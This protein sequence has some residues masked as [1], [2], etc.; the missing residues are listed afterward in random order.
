MILKNKNFLLLFLS[1]FSSVFGDA[2]LFILLL[3]MLDN[4]NTSSVGLSLFYIY[5]TIPAL[6]FSVPAGAII[7]KNYLQKVMSI[8][9]INRIIL[10][11][12][13]ILLQFISSPSQ[14]SIY[15]LVFMVMANHVFYIPANS[16]LLTKIVKKEDVVNANSHIQITMMVAR[17]G[18]YACSAWLIKIGIS[19][20]NILFIIA[21]IYALSLA[22]IIS[23]KPYYKSHKNNSNTSYFQDI[24][25]GMNYIKS[26]RIFSR[27]F[28]IFG[29]SWI[30][31]SSIDIFLISY[32]T[33]I[34]NRGPEDL[35]LITT[36]SLIG[37]TIG[38]LLAPYLYRKIDAKIGILLSSLFFSIVIIL[39]SLKLPIWILLISL[40]I[41]GITQGLF[42]IFINTYLQTHVQENLL[43][44][45]YSFYNLL[46]TGATLPG[47]LLFGY[48]I[49]YMGVINT[50][51]IISIYLFFAS[52]MTMAILPKMNSN[53]KLTETK[54]LNY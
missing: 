12:S 26:N 6:L 3:T 5:S 38:S 32:L 36:F 18:S 1:R 33:N 44:R 41:G 20:N 25:E 13:L 7:E 39:F 11:L 17:L 50:G 37:I 8:T 52:L 30:V 46:Y 23:I 9:N 22:F 40:F 54:E 16:S 48:L 49:K 43:A 45:V 14:T 42:L 35:Y 15:L 4:L 27:L 53:S 19:F 21:L 24:S 34:L 47:Y 2:M 51:F 31:G 28:L 10:I 29:L